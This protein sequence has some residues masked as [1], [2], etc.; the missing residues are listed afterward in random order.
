MDL[1]TEILGQR[2]YDGEIDGEQ[3]DTFK[4]GEVFFVDIF[5]PK[6]NYHIPRFHTTKGLFTFITT[7]EACKQIF[8]PL[9]FVALDVN[10]LVNVQ[11]IIEVTKTFY[12]I[13]AHFEGGYTA[14]VA[15]G[16]LPL[17]EHLLKKS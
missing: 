6:K 16:K 5:Q 13:T 11:H 14:N 10:N 9:G 15:K 8:L 2:I 17:V 7:L 12:A 1:T 4:L 3:F